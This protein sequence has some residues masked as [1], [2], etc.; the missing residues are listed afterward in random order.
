MT[1]CIGNWAV[2]GSLGLILFFGAAFLQR[3][4]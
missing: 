2:R 3:R 1:Y 4:A